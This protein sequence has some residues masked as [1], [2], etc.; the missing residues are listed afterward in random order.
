MADKK[1]E[2]AVYYDGPWLNDDAVIR[3]A[4]SSPEDAVREAI[5]LVGPPKI[6]SVQEVS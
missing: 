5:A 2:V 6:G 1:Y 3:L 4:A